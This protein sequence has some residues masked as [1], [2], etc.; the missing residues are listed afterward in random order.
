VLVWAVTAWVY[1]SATTR[2]SRILVG[3]M[4]GVM[5]YGPNQSDLFRRAATYADKILKGANARNLPIE[6]PTRFE[7]VV[8]LKTAEAL[9]LTIPQ[10]VLPRADEVIGCSEK[11]GEWTAPE[12]AAGR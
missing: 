5:A 6:H 11:A 4:M 3:L 8:N 1:T 9:S 7:L 12:S 2:L 10:S